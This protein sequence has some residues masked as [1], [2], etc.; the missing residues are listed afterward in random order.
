LDLQ[1]QPLD[2]MGSTID[3]GTKNEQ[4]ANQAL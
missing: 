1:L 4:N 2:C 3:D